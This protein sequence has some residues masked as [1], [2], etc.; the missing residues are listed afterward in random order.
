MLNALRRLCERLSVSPPILRGK[1]RRRRHGDKQNRDVGEGGIC[2]ISLCECFSYASVRAKR[3]REVEW[4][5]PAG[6][7]L[8]AAAAFFVK[9]LARD[10]LIFLPLSLSYAHSLLRLRHKT[11]EVP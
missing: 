8:H 7:E 10:T 6:T 1:L 11:N 4:S 5:M 9:D 3:W 2:K